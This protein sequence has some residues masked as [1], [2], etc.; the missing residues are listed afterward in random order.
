MLR[1]CMK[2]ASNPAVTMQL[3]PPHSGHCTISR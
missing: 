2:K 1:H 3:T